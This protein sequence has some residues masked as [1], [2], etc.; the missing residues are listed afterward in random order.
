MKKC[1][2]R[3][4]GQ[5]FDENDPE[6]ILCMGENSEFC[7]EECETDEDFISCYGKDEFERACR[8]EELEEQQANEEWI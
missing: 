2:Y 7:S 4:C 6:F 5:S 3:N 1:K 8:Q